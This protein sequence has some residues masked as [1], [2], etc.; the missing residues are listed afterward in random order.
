MFPFH[1]PDKQNNEFKKLL[2]VNLYSTKNRRQLSEKVNLN[3]LES[4]SPKNVLVE[5]GQV[6]LEKNMKIWIVHN[7]RQNSSDLLA[8]DQS[9]Y[10]WMLATQTFWFPG[11]VHKSG[12]LGDFLLSRVVGRRL[13]HFAL[14]DVPSLVLWVVEDVQVVWTKQHSTTHMYNNHCQVWTQSLT[15]D[16]IPVL[17]I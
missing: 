11:F 10:L 3:K 16:F 12:F 5:I 15:S 7:N 14:L 2:K 1:Y 13:R 8:H 9:W 4:P 6:V 17:Y